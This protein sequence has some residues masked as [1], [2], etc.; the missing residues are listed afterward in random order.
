MH[1]NSDTRQL[2]SDCETKSKDKTVRMNQEDRRLEEIE[3]EASPDRFEIADGGTPEVEKTLN[4]MEKVE[5]RETLSRTVTGVSS[6]SSGSSSSGDSVEREEIGISRL[7]TQRD[8]V[9]LDRHPT[10]LSRIQTGRSQHSA[11]VGASIRSRTATRHSRTALPAFGAGKPYPPPLPEREEY[12]VE[13]DGVNDPLHA[14]NWPMKKKLP[15]AIT[16][17]FVTL[18]AAFGSSIFS[19]ATGVVA[20]QFNISRQFG[21]LGVSLYVLGFATGPIVWAPSSELYGRKIPLLISS[22][23]FSIFNI[24]VAVAKDT[25]TIFICRFFAGF[26]GAVSIVWK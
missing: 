16:L 19:T 25:Q 8:D 12:V 21:I 1:S 15:V 13:F 9:D 2:A 4:P 5:R 11:T 17:G 24:A 26:A 14:Q 7:A 10:S 6:S 18:T 20:Q 22:F 23:M 3:R